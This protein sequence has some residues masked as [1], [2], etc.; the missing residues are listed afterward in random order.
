L[1]GVSVSG[2]GDVNADG[3]DDVIIGAI[4]ARPLEVEAGSAT[5]FS[6]RDGS[7]LHC[8]ISDS[9]LDGFGGSVSC[10]DDVNKDGFDDVIVGASGNDLDG[11][12]DAGSATVFS[13]RD[14]AVLHYFLGDSPRDFFGASVSGAGDVNRDGVPDLIV[15]ASEDAPDGI[16]RTGSAKVFSGS[17][18]CPL[19]D[20]MDSEL[21]HDIEIFGLG[22]VCTANLTGL[23]GVQRSCEYVDKVT[24][25]PTVD[26]TIVKLDLRG[27][28]PNCGPITI[29]LQFNRADPQPV[30]LSGNSPVR[31]SLLTAIST[32]TFRSQFPTSASH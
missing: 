11:L 23:V 16:S 8:F 30:R 15:G 27:R 22:Q 19:H 31:C 29:S 1:F 24:G 17:P 14:G 4:F 7:V 28:D 13:G 6:G 2:A 18:S 20:L 12:M 5:V 21:V 10:A 3:F 25:R 32:S 9:Q 26:T